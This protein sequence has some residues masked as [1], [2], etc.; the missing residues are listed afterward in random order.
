MQAGVVETATSTHGWN[1]RPRA[2][3]PLRVS[4]TACARE[5]RDKRTRQDA[6]MDTDVTRQLRTRY[7]DLTPA[8]RQVCLRRLE[9]Y[10]G[11]RRATVDA[12]RATE[13]SNTTLLYLSHLHAVHGSAVL[14]TKWGSRNPDARVDFFFDSIRALLEFESSPLVSESP[15]S[16]DDWLP[17]FVTG[18]RGPPDQRHEPAS[19][20]RWHAGFVAGHECTQGAGTSCA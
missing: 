5:P 15:E 2:P 1:G 20:S 13:T 18:L 12:P 10:F 7:A 19:G 3:F 14:A 4:V 17:G 6:R 16:R 9:A 8:S 11:H